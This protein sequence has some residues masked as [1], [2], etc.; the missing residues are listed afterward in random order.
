MASKQKFH[1]GDR[2]QWSSGQGTSTGT[3]QTRIT[4]DQVVDGN[5]ISA[6]ADD[7]RYLVKNDNT[8]TVTG[9]RLDA[10]SKPDDSSSSRSSSSNSVT[11]FEKGDRVQ[12]NT[13]QGKTVGTVQ[14]RLTE[15]TDI[16]GHTA[17]ASKEEP[18]YLVKS[19][20][21]GAEAAHKPDALEKI[22]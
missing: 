2:V 21:T 13:S 10:L 5:Q 3:V 8:G 15:P 4:E 16:A 1:K 12:W 14:K 19:E 20:S 22:S 11:Q 6:S 18:Q 17:K 9:H 7:P